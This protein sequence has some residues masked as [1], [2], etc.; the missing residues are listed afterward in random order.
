M[1]FRKTLLAAVVLVS[2]A[3]LMQGAPTSPAHISNWVP[4]EHPASIAEWQAKWA[5]PQAIPDVTIFGTRANLMRGELY[6]IF[7]MG[8][9]DASEAILRHRHWSLAH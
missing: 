1:M 9:P 7:Y 3:S 5:N 2:S 4:A 8:Y 6:Y